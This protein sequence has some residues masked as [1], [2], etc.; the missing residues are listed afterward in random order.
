MQM[1]KMLKKF[2][3]VFISVFA[4]LSCEGTK[5]Y[6]LTLSVKT[7]TGNPI[8][9]A[10]VKVD[11]TVVGKTDAKGEFDGK[12]VLRQGEDAKLEVSK[13]SSDFY[14]APYFKKFAVPEDNAKA[15]EFEAVLY[16]VPKPKVVAGNDEGKEEEKSE[17]TP[18]APV[19]VSETGSSVKNEIETPKIETAVNEKEVE[20]KK[21][22]VQTENKPVEDSP[23]KT[24]AELELEGELDVIN[25][26]SVTPVL[27]G[28][29]EGSGQKEAYPKKAQASAGDFVFTIQSFYKKKGLSGVTIYK[30]E[31]K[32]GELREFCSTTKRG[33][34][35]V[36]F[37]VS[38][39]QRVTFVAK[40]KGYKTVSKTVKVK[41][42]GVLRF[43]LEKGNG[44]DFFATTRRYNYIKGL[45]DTEVYID[46]KI[47]GKTDEFGR[48][49]YFHTGSKDDLIDVMLKPQGYLPEVYQ[50]DFV[51]QGPMTV[52]KYFAPKEPPVAKIG[53]LPIRFTGDNSDDAAKNFKGL[54]R[55]IITRKIADLDAFRRVGISSVQ[56]GFEESELTVSQATKQGWNDTD[57]KSMVDALI[58]PTIASSGGETRLEISVV[59]SL[60]RVLAAAREDLSGENKRKMIDQA[61]ATVVEKIERLFPFEGTLTEAKENLVINIGSSHKRALSKGDQVFVWGVQSDKTGKKREH[62][63]IATLEVTEVLEDSSNMKLVWKAAR[64]AL[65]RGD[66]VQIERTANRDL[67]V[68]KEDFKKQNNSYFAVKTNGEKK[69]VESAN[70]YFNGS[71]IGTTGKD[72]TLRFPQNIIG[73][74]GDVQVTK[75]GY[76]SITKKLDLDKNKTVTIFIQHKKAYLKISSKPSGAKVFAD[77]K[78]IGKTPVNK[79]ISL[80]GEFVELEIKGI[81]GYKDFKTVAELDDSTLDLTGPKRVL[82]E[83][84]YLR[85]AIDSLESG[86]VDLALKK[87]SEIEPSHSDYLKA[88]HTMAETYLSISDDPENAIKEFSTVTSN[89]EVSSF[90]DKRYVSAFVNLGVSHFK[91]AEKLGKDKDWEKVVLNYKNAISQFDKAKPYLRFISRSAYGKVVHSVSFH[92]ALA[93]HRIA[94]I[95][96]DRGLLEDAYE[97]WRNYVE[98]TSGAVRLAND[99]KEAFID[100]AKIYLRQ[101]RVSLRRKSF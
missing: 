56:K 43:D 25:S 76:A 7:N 42:N 95:T 37:Q 85:P 92:A 46:G 64:A 3:L 27:A 62:N 5:E 6:P 53:V 15:L 23:V 32:K 72:G 1:V 2:I 101:A 44:I 54:V 33:R 73:Q 99:D 90:R 87:L 59:D 21:V 47:V 19:V 68:S 18:E 91:F 8:E 55:P 49:S 58:V 16:S 35:V 65:Q 40:K 10:S 9:G 89:P 30:G 48:F 79:S 84:D 31:T 41:D 77:G 24:K 4:F 51:I 88:R 50:T 67:F 52:V 78:L 13:D 71:W 93:K 86:N 29:G 45:K 81:K 74:S 20:E 36:R 70:L 34:C 11:Q 96:K 75:P 57:L 61:V 12:A 17:D 80:N 63:H 98:G 22:V 38:P 28:V 26:K 97:D 82:L 60:G 69:P 66:L 100:N 14:Y 39:S 94:L 83:I